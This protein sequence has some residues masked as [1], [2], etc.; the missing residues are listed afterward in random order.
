MVDARLEGPTQTCFANGTPGAHALSSSDLGEHPGAYAD[1]EEQLGVFV[2]AGSLRSPVH[3][4]AIFG[5]LNLGRRCM[6]GG[7]T[8]R[9]QLGGLSADTCGY[10]WPLAGVRITLR[11]K[12][13]AE[14]EK[15]LALGTGTGEN[16]CP[17]RRWRLGGLV[18][19]RRAILATHN[20]EAECRLGE[21]EAKVR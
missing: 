20:C 4:A 11:G 17:S 9:R 13:D 18:V 6:N 1:G 21:A 16:E 12:G 5:V 15:P 3:W 14:G 10:A 7:T 19:V 2:Q 8:Q